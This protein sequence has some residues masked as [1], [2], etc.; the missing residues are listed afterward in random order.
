MTCSPWI[1][2]IGAPA[3]PYDCPTGG[4]RDSRRERRRWSA[5]LTHDEVRAVFPESVISILD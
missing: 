2:P 5:P 4:H 1:E 3:A